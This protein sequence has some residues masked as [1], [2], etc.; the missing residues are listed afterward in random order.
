MHSKPAVGT[1]ELYVGILCGSFN[2]S[3]FFPTLDDTTIIMI[4]YTCQVDL[5]LSSESIIVFLFVLSLFSI[6]FSDLQN[7]FLHNEPYST[8]QS[9]CVSCFIKVRKI[10]T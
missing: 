10:F 1:N 2:F 7:T 3:F 4:I 8:F 6:L 5:L 9:F